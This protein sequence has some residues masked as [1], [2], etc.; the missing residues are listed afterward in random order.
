MLCHGEPLA[1]SAHWVL[2]RILEN[3]EVSYGVNVVACIF[4]PF[5]LKKLSKVEDLRITSLLV[6]SRAS[7]ID[8]RKI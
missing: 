2:A 3:D 4:D 1:G 5:R 8:I 6:S 7:G